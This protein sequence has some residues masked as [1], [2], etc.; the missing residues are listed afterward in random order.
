MW[1]FLTLALVPFNTSDIVQRNY[2]NNELCYIRL[3]GVSIL[4]S[5]GNKAFGLKESI[6]IPGIPFLTKGEFNRPIGSKDDFYR[7]FQISDIH[8]FDNNTD[9]CEE[10]RGAVE[11]KVAYLRSV[12]KG[13]LGCK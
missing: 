9:Y 13:C 11:R 6:D 4:D 5:N 3:Y 8:N 10:L 1:K 12:D 2:T 7:M